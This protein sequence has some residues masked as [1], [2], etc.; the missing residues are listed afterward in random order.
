MAEEQTMG[1]AGPAQTPDDSEPGWMGAIPLIGPLV[2]VIFLVV[3][4]SPDEERR[5]ERAE[6]ARQE[7]AALVAG[8]TAVPTSTQASTESETTDTAETATKT[9][10]VQLTEPEPMATDIVASAGPNKSSSGTTYLNAAF[11]EAEAEVST[12]EAAADTTEPVIAAGAPDI[13]EPSGGFDNPWAPLDPESPGA[14]FDLWA[15]AEVPPPP[16]GAAGPGPH[17]QAM[18]AQPGVAGGA[19]PPQWGAGAPMY[20]PCPAPYYWCVPAGPPGTQQ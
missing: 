6:E 3:L 17:G 4:V 13:A 8:T 9:I 5:A 10:D 20:V 2:I 1:G 14:G 19:Y 18:G 12:G 7:A 16:P 15:S 11:A